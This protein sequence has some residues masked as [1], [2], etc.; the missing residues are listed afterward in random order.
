MAGGISEGPTEHTEDTEKSEGKNRRV[1]RERTR[2]LWSGRDRRD[3]HK[4]YKGVLAAAESALR[5]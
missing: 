1:S 4:K 5:L 3:G 2:R